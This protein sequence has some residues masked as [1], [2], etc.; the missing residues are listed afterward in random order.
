MLNHSLGATEYWDHLDDAL[1]CL[2]PRGYAV[3]S[4]RLVDSILAGC[5]PVI[6]A[7]EYWMPLSCLVDW[8]RFAVFV[9]ERLV[10]SAAQIVAA[11][12]AARVAHMQSYLLR[13]R[14]MFMFASTSPESQTVAPT[15]TRGQ[16]QGHGDGALLADGFMLLMLEVYLR[17][18]V[19]PSVS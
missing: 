15:A 1:F 3:W 8:R 17:K 13:V 6:V 14:H 9:P 10:D 5:L 7:D 2:C 4:P 12:P 16:G 11:L 19:C 18:Q